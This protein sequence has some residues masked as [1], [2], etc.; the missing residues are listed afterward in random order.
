VPF[1]R[2]PN[3]EDPIF[4]IDRANQM[5]NAFPHVLSKGIQKGQYDEKAFIGWKNF[6]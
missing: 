6:F 2:Q 3:Y 5:A 1:Q 4:V